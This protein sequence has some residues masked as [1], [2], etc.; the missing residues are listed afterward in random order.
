MATND[1][2]KVVAGVFKS[3]K[4]EGVAIAILIVF[5]V[6]LVWFAHTA[7]TETDVIWMRL[8]V[9]YKGLE[10][11]AFTAA[12]VL[13]G[14]R[15]QRAHVESAEARAA[16]SQQEARGATEAAASAEA[17]GRSL[18]SAIE[19]AAVSRSAFETDDGSDRNQGLVNLAR[20]LFPDRS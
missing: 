5:A 17:R 2:N 10:A 3:T 19:G 15:V 1:D 11:L 12:G 9:L 8:M 6:A 14:T 4:T 13:L 20:Q 16:S 18:R 7:K